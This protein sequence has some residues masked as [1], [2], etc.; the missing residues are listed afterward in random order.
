MKFKI[1]DDGNGSPLFKTGEEDANGQPVVWG[2]AGDVIDVPIDSQDPAM[3]TKASHWLRGNHN[4]VENVPAAAR[5]AVTDKPAPTLN[6]AMEGGVV[7]KA[8]SEK[9]GG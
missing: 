5:A 9:K 8:T 1:K 3:R 2:Q 7:N 4:R 6:R